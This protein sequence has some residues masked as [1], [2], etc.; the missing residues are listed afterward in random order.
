MKV[1]RTLGYDVRYTHG[2]GAYL[3][4]EHGTRYIDCLGGFGVF[5]VGRNHP[6][7]REGLKQ[8]MHLDLPGLPK[9]GVP[10][11]SGLL[12]ERLIAIAPGDLDTVFFCNSGAE[13]IEA[14]IK[15]SRA[16]T[17]RQRIVYCNKAY[18][19]LTYGALSLNGGSEFREGFGHMLTDCTQIPFNDL[20]ALEHELAKGD[21]AGFIVEPIQGKGIFVANDDY[22]PGAARLCHKHGAL[23]TLEEVQT[24]FGRTGRMFAAEHWGI[25]PDILVTAK[26]LSGGYVPIAAVLCKRWI[27]DK[28]FGSM[29]RCMVHS[30]TFSQN[31]L[32]MAAGLLTLHVISREHIVENAATMGDRLKRR[33]EAMRDQYEMVHDVRGKGLMLG[34]EFGPPRSMTLKMGW[35]LLHRVDQSLFPQAM[36]IPL[37]QD[38]HILAQVAGHHMDV[39]ECT[40]PLVLREQDV[41]AI[42]DGVEAVVSACHKFPGPVWEVGKRLSQAIAR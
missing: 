16:A 40:P 12:A 6:V 15:Y 18:H 11:L 5:G 8:A 27:H 38:H 9:F 37:L 31:D 10:R 26:A 21:V 19:G 30:S 32:A 24:G 23:L 13:G 36:L 2:R 25:E 1:L 22:L 34:I 39:I 35:S 17:K 42:A 20:D 4:D 14:A 28:V 29:G 7:V 3:Y 41:D 33:L